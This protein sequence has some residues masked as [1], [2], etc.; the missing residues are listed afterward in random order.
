MNL[1]DKQ[2]NDFIIQEQKIG[3]NDKIV[4]NSVGNTKF[5]TYITAQ[6]ITEN[7]KPLSTQYVLQRFFYAIS[8]LRFQ[9]VSEC[10]Q[11]Y[12]FQ[13]PYTLWLPDVRR[14]DNVHAEP[15]G[16]YIRKHVRYVHNQE[17]C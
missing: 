16:R 11:E 2:R 15:D 13:I 7:I 1:K 9:S 5:E 4:I 8:F 10:L 17:Y 12:P 6:K 3:E 14:P